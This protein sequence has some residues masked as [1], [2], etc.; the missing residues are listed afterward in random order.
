[1]ITIKKIID[2]YYINQELLNSNF[3]MKTLIIFSIINIY[4]Q[5]REMKLQ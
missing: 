3:F 2:I 1:M 5:R 4:L